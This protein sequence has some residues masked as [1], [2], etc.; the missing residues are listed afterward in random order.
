MTLS[1]SGCGTINSTLAGKTETTEYYRVYDIKTDASVHQLGDPAAE[2]IEKDIKDL[3]TTYPINMSGE[4]PENPG[5][6]TLQNP[7]KGT[8]IGALA[9][10]TGSI[11][12]KIASCDGASWTAKSRRSSSSRAHQALSFCLFPYQGGYQLAMYGQL[13]AQH[14]G[15]GPEALAT[16]LVRSTIG[17]PKEFLEKTF[18][19]ALVS[20]HEAVPDAEFSFVRG[21]PKPGPLPWISGTILGE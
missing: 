18:Q 12:I 10:G 5:H 2:G 16:K 19:D 9:G 8:A 13:T 21:Q 17:S 14:G 20:M 6:M 15:I 1:L 3:R 7:F 4:I 11:G